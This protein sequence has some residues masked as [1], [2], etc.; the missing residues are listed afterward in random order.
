LNSTKFRFNIAGNGKIYKYNW[1]RTMK[2]DLK[3]PNCGSENTQN[4][5]VLYEGGTIE[6]HGMSNTSGGN[7]IRTPFERKSYTTF[8]SSTSHSK[9]ALKHIPPQKKGTVGLV[10][11]ISFIGLFIAALFGLFMWSSTA[12]WF[13][14]IIITLISLPFASSN[15]DYNK[16]EYPSLYNNWAKQYYCHKCGK[17]FVPESVK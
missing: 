13:I 5:E 15:S 11:M 4:V 16:N 17:I 6:S 9:L 10:I 7:V 8:T 12:F 2:L 14:C 3:C 1:K